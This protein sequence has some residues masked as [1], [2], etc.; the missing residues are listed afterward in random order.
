MRCVGHTTIAPRAALLWDPCRSK[1]SGRGWGA[2]FEAGLGAGLGI[3]H[4]GGRTSARSRQ[5]VPRPFKDPRRP[6]AETDST[7]PP[8]PQP[9]PVWPSTGSAALP[10]QQRERARTSQPIGCGLRSGL[11]CSPAHGHWSNW[12]GDDD[13]PGPLSLSLTSAGVRGKSWRGQEAGTA[14]ALA[15]CA[16]SASQ[17]APACPRSTCGWDCAR[18]TPTPGS[19]PALTRR[20][21]APIIA[22]PAA[23]SGKPWFPRRVDRTPPGQNGPCSR[24]TKRVRCCI[25]LEPYF[26]P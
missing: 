5:R 21:S 18:R 2:G 12:A 15:P 8:H 13:T 16:F 26:P 7:H 19:P 1:V 24:L 10:W 20:A 14:S 25:C 11:K 17:G 6:E 3:G 23:R 4:R 22:S 9:P